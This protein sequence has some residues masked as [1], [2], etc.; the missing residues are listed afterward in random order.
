MWKMKIKKYR[1]AMLLVT[2]NM[3]SVSDAPKL[4]AVNTM[5][6]MLTG[7]RSS[8][9]FKNN[10]IMTPFMAKLLENMAIQ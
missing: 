1:Q 3:G 6:N 8:L 10:H 5:T 9:N 2:T 4:N 7:V